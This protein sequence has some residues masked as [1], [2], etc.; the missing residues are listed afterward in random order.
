MDTALIMMMV[1]FEILTAINANTTTYLLFMLVCV[2]EGYFIWITESVKPDARTQP[3]DTG[4]IN[5]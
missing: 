4:N 2:N 5:I 1:I 3:C